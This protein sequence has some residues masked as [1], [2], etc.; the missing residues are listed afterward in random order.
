[1]LNVLHKDYN[2]GTLKTDYQIHYFL[3]FCL[4]VFLTNII[5]ISYLSFFT[6][7]SNP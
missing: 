2:R 6:V 5:P 1:M 7:E 4:F 3:L